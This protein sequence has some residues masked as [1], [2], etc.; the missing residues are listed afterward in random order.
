MSEVTGPL[1]LALVLDVGCA[2]RC[3]LLHS[4]ATF[5]LMIAVLAPLSLPLAVAVL[6]PL[7]LALAVAVLAPLTLALAVAALPCQRARR[8]DRL[9]VP[10][11]CVELSSGSLA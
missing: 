9:A 1:R 4:I 3:L 11:N 7:S 2:T 10:N 5:A 8:R 6:A